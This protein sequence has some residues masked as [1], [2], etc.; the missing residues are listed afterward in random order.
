MVGSLD[1]VVVF[2]SRKMEA[3]GEKLVEVLAK[4]EARHKYCPE[5]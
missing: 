1:L 3:E 5:T 4:F 2:L